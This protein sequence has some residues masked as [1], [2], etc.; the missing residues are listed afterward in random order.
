MNALYYPFHLCHD[1][2]LRRVCE[3]YGE[4][5]F[6]DYM[7]L[8][9][10][11]LVGT[12]AF[13]DRIGDAHP[14][15]LKAG[16]IVQ[17]HHV[18][19]PMSSEVIIAVNR[20]LADLQ[21]RTVF[22]DALTEDFR[23]QRGLFPLLEKQGSAE[24]ATLAIPSWMTCGITEWKTMPYS[25]EAVQA[26]THRQLPGHEEERFEYGFALIKTA[27]ALVNTIRLCRQLDLVAVTD[28]IAHHQLLTRT[29]QR[30]GIE[31]L[32]HLIQREGY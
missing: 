24:S 11:P 14:E 32:N 2:T 10:T 18:S 7:A 30:D 27:A 8:Q 25:V 16:K 4:V 23:F 22:H 1:L 26:L 13:P 19:G 31:L 21:W 28:S 6:R 29:C 3:E 20:D 9:L 12:T 5:H 17:G 15:L